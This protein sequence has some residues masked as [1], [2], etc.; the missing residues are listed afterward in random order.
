MS[1]HELMLAQVGQV[2]TQVARPYPYD[3]PL[4]VDIQA[5]VWR[6]GLA[7]DELTSREELVA[8]LWA[9]KR[10]LSLAI[11]PTWG[12]PGATPPNAA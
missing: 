4:P 5:R 2:L 3:A 1:E 9:R 11:Q 10:S 12:G 8:R 6:L 7:C